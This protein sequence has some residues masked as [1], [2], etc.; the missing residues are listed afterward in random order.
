MVF[1]GAA[2]VLC[3]LPEDVIEKKINTEQA[4][5]FEWKYFRNLHLLYVVFSEVGGTIELVSK[6]EEEVEVQSNQ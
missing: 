6:S 1:S 4:Q 2:G 3:S 5:G